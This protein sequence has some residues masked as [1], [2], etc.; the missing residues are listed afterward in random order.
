MSKKHAAP[1]KESIFSAIASWVRGSLADEKKRGSIYGL[2]AAVLAVL[3]AYGVCSADDA[4]Q[5]AE[6]VATALTALAALLARANTGS[7]GSVSETV[8]ASNQVLYVEA[9]EGDISDE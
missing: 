5:Y 6:A 8:A 3:T 2:A 4:A 1:G 9:M 7:V